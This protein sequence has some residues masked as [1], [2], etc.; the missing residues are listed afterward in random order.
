LYAESTSPRRVA[1]SSTTTAAVAGTG[2]ARVSSD[3]QS[4]SIACPDAP[5][6]EMS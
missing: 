3:R 6:A 4:M 1:V 2:T 5:D